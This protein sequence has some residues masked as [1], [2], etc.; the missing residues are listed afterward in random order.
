M[1]GKQG[2]EFSFRD[3]N[4]PRDGRLRAAQHARRFRVRKVLEIH[5][6]HGRALIRRQN[7][8][9]FASRIELRRTLF[10]VDLCAELHRVCQ[11]PPSRLRP[12]P[13]AHGVCANPVEPMM[14]RRAR[15]VVAD[16]ACRFDE[17]LLRNVL[18]GGVIE[19]ET[20]CESVDHRI[21]TVEKFGKSLG[22]SRDGR[23][24]SGPFINGVRG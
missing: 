6:N 20:E 21:V 16:G 7:G 10:R 19:A 9:R 14:K 2:F 22:V 1:L 8:Q 18:R 24:D 3:E 23:L 4:P 17:C 11:L 5:S 13:V 15:T 12:L